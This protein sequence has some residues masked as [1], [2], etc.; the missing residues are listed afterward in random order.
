MLLMGV[1]NTLFGR[2]VVGTE[3]IDELVNIWS[4]VCIIKN[5]GLVLCMMKLGNDRL[6]P[7]G[8]TIGLCGLN[9]GSSVL[10]VVQTSDNR[11]WTDNSC[12]NEMGIRTS[13][14][15]VRSSISIVVGL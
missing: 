8:L 12:V 13:G 4:K 5:S 14:I 11:R 6:F 9:L 2:G 7:L 3:Q 15:D 10:V 1:E